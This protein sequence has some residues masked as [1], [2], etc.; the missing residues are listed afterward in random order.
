MGEPYLI[1][2]LTPHKFPFRVFC[3]GCRRVTYVTASAYN[4]LSI[5]SPPTTRPS[6]ASSDD[7]VSS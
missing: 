2:D 5:V 7:S 6:D 3:F 1:G 4:R